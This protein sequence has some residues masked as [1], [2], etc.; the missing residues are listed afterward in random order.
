MVFRE[1]ERISAGE[2]TF[3]HIER[4]PVENDEW[5]HLC[6]DQREQT[7][8]QYAANDPTTSSRRWTHDH[9]FHRSRS[10]RCSS[11]RLVLV[12]Y[13]YAMASSERRRQVRSVRINLGAWRRQQV[14]GSWFD[15]PASRTSS[16]PFLLFALTTFFPSSSLLPS[17]RQTRFV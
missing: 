6:R 13:A 4:V 5:R 14:L 10:I 15:A 1:R 16:S 3:N 8:E 11:E 9:A 2:T 7:T 12:H 17:S